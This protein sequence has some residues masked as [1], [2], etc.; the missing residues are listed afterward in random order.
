MEAISLIRCRSSTIRLSLC[1]VDPARRD[2][3]SSRVDRQIRLCAL[4]L[5]RQVIRNSASNCPVH[6]GVY[7]LL[8]VTMPGPVL[9][10]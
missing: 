4:D 3:Q 5:L 9:R 10:L 1:S 7:L 6:P 8:P 2:T